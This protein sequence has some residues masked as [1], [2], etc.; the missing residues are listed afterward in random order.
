MSR[1]FRTL[2]ALVLA[3]AATAA[4]A[5]ATTVNHVLADPT[6]YRDRSV[7]VSGRVRD[8]V[9]IGRHGAYR[10]EDRTGSLWVVSD[11]GVPRS[12]ARVKVKGRVRDMFN[13][14]LFGSRLGLPPG[15]SSG[16]VLQEE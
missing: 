5:C 15:L 13:L 11:A 10:I 16:V 6:K 4:S 7:T 8:S 1:S 9:S 14:S 2:S 12:G 3:V